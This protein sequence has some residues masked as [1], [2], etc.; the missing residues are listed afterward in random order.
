MSDS[1]TYAKTS[2]MKNKIYY[3]RHYIVSTCRNT[4]DWPADWVNIMTQIYYFPFSCRTLQQNLY[5]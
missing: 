5:F 4:A 2:L 3:V 1:R